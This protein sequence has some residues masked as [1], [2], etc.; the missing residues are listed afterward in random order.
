MQRLFISPMI[1]KM[2][3]PLSSYVSELCISTQYKLFIL[4]IIG[5]FIIWLFSK[6][7][8]LKQLLSIVVG[9]FMM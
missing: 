2:L 7:D 3:L 5:K 8:Y 9:K 4:F 1:C 6:L